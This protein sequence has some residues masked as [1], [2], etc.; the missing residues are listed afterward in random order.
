MARTQV[1]IEEE[2]RTIDAAIATLLSGNKLKVLKVGSGDF[3]RQYEEHSIN[4]TELY[5][6]RKSLYDELATVTN[7]VP[8]FNRGGFIPMVGRK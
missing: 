3:A 1:V 8:V 7:A 4:L 2:I 5:K 6:I